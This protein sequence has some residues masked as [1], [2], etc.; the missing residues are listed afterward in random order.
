MNRTAEAIGEA[1]LEAGGEVVEVTGEGVLATFGDGEAALAAA[2]GIERRFDALATRLV[3]ETGVEPVV[4]VGVHAGLVVSGEIGF[5]GSR[6]RAIV[7]R[8]VDDARRLPGLARDAGRRYA[9]TGAAL[10][11]DADV[12]FADAVPATVRTA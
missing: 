10:N 1:V 5:R 12:S 6:T 9:F 2:R 4:H 11:S 3:A 8:A 7:G